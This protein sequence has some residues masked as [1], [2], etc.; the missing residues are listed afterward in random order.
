M[1][2]RLEFEMDL[3]HKVGFVVFK[4]SDLFGT[5]RLIEHADGL[6]QFASFVA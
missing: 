4:L 6:V 5:L 1:R 2:F 3:L